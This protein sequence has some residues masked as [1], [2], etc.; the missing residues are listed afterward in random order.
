VIQRISL[1]AILYLCWIHTP[2]R[3]GN[4]SI[5]GNPHPLFCESR[6]LCH[7]HV[8]KRENYLGNA[9]SLLCNIIYPQN[10]KVSIS[11]YEI[12]QYHERRRTVVILVISRG[13][14]KAQKKSDTQNMY[15][16]AHK[17]FARTQKFCSRTQNV[18]SHVTHTQNIKATLGP[19]YIST[20]M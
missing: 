12:V 4:Y 6:G 14:W 2:S 20:C 16:L 7:P 1:S 9:H 8:E 19:P 5:T 15:L 18:L 17:M 3:L 10:S 13:S 11:L